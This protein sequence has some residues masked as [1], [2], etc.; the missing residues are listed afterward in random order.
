MIWFS[1]YNS[2]SHLS[3]LCVDYAFN[4]FT[5]VHLE[6]I[7]NRAWDRRTFSLNSSHLSTLKFVSWL[8]LHRF[9]FVSIGGYLLWV[10]LWC[11][12]FHWTSPAL[13]EISV[14]IVWSFT[15]FHL[16]LMM[17]NVWAICGL[18][19]VNRSRVLLNISSPYRVRNALILYSDSHPSSA[20][21]AHWLSDFLYLQ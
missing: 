12:C 18:N 17:R 14:C 10:S 20:V 1:G 6:Q 5:C 3:N 4:R 2:S 11:L 15:S 19:P 7:D 21:V 9:L 16:C 8:S 13:N